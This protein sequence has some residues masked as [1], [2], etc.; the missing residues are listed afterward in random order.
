MGLYPL[1]ALYPLKAPD[2]LTALK[3]ADHLNGPTIPNLLGTPVQQLT[4]YFQV[5]PVVSV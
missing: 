2:Q 1:M 4:Q 3:R 5:M